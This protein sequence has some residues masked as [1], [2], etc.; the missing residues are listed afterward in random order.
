MV[1]AGLVTLAFAACPV[2]AVAAA[3][4]PPVTEAHAVWTEEGHVQLDVTWD[5]GA[6][7]EPG[8]PAVEAGSDG[9]NTVVVPT[10]E[11]AEV[12]TLQI[13]PVTFSG[14]IAVEPTAE[15]LSIM[16]LAPDGQPKATGSVEI[17]VQSDETSAE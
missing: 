1:R 11:T 12:C 6:C 10:V 13:V 2:V 9:T 3:P 4:P 14:L 15:T 7:E 5:G 16:V 17:V 8:E